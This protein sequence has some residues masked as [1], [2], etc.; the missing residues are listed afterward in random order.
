MRLVVAPF[1]SIVAHGHG[2]NIAAASAGAVSTSSGPPLRTEFMRPR[3]LGWQE[4]TSSAGAWMPSQH[5]SSRAAAGALTTRHALKKR[6]D[7]RAARGLRL[8]IRFA[9]DMN[10]TPKGAKV[11]RE[12]WM[13]KWKAELFWS[14][15]AFHSFCASGSRSTARPTF[16]S[17]VAPQPTQ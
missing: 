3:T 7:I 14:S 4:K 2:L 12:Q 1:E 17:T 16:R 15:P 10:G 13:A 11:L 8:R 9:H 6:Y 5:A